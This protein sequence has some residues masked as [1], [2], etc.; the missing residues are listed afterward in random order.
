[1]SLGDLVIRGLVAD[2]NVACSVCGRRFRRSGLR[3]LR[4]EQNVWQIS[5][6]CGQCE[7]VSIFVVKLDTSGLAE[8]VVDD[9]ELT[10]TEQERFSAEPPIGA[11]EV[12]AMAD[13]LA[14]FDGD[15]QALFAPPAEV[16][17]E[18]A[19]EAASS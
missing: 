2:H 8:D 12:L 15:F 13:F 4:R 11:D 5:G 10:D 6:R 7:N 1:M 14:A 19:G 18:D 9:V 3:V 17:A 16:T